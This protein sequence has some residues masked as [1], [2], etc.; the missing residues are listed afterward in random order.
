MNLARTKARHR[1]AAAASALALVAT[2]GA[3]SALAGGPPAPAF[4]V[5]DV[6]YRTIGT[7]T[8]L[9]GT[10]AP[11]H[12]YDRIY[13][14]GA[15]LMNVSE[16]KPGD[17]DYNGGRWMVLPVT[18]AVGVTPVQ[19][20][21]DAAILEAAGDGLLTIGAPVKYFVCPVIPMPGSRAGR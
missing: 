21:S 17:R 11:A 8:D 5:D 13:A 6:L 10:G 9:S 1:F 3:G 16:A 19:L 2:L 15:G 4:Y 7:P 18:W 14:L 20:T 12:S